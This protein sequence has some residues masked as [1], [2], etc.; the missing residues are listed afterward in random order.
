M[1]N[2]Y[3]FLGLLRL[4]LDYI[5]T[6]MFTPQCRIIRRPVY[7]RGTKFINWGKGLT[8]GVNLRIDVF[9]IEGHP[10]P[11][12]QIGHNC[13]INDY[14]H[15]GVINSVIIGNNVLIASKVF[16]SDH[17]HGDFEKD[18]ELDLPPSKRKLTS[19]A[20]RICD[21]VW[22]GE[23]VMILPGV[24]IGKSSIIGAGAIVTKNIPEYS[25]AVGNPARVV[26]QYNQTINKW[27]RI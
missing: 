6:K 14:V 8:S 10:N 15:I 21:D 22:I 17:N 24:T 23:G 1:L 13:Q 11:N 3:G 26:K 25:I 12:L 9:N 20:T 18:P 4:G 5:K 2:T 7:I 27:V 16:I 19:A